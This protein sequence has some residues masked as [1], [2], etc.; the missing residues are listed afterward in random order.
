MSQKDRRS[1]RRSDE[2]RRRDVL[3]FQ[4][5]LIDADNAT[6]KDLSRIQGIKNVAYILASSAPMYFLYRI[7]DELAGEQTEFTGT[8]TAS[9]ALSLVCGGGWANERRR[10]RSQRA[11]LERVRA[12]Q[13]TL[14]STLA[15]LETESEIS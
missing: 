13:Q 12:R 7:F 2:Q 11:E 14:E 15:E 6:K 3:A 10:S 5:D 1:P 4:R 8:V 9:F